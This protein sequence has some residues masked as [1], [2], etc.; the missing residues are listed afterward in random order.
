MLKPANEAPASG[1]TITAAQALAR[2]PVTGRFLGTDGCGRSEA[3][4]Q[5]IA[6]RR[7]QVAKLYPDK[8][9]A[10]I[11]AELGW[12]TP[13]IWQDVKALGLERRRPGA[14]RKHPK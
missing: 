2:D 6:D 13:T 11:G 14:R 12:K 7:A 8:T 5:V 1:P 4:R 3:E 10:E 9:C